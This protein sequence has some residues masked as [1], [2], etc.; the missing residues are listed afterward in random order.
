MNR[1]M[2]RGSAALAGAAAVVFA[3]VI[4]LGQK[5]GDHSHEG[6][7]QPWSKYHVHDMDRPVPPIVTPGDPS[8]AEKPGTA[9]SD[10]VVLFDGKDMS[11][12]QGAGG[13]E[14][15]FKLQ[16]GVM[17]SYGPKN[18]QSK[19]K[20]GDVQLHVEWA[21]PTPAQGDSQGRGNS[22]VFLMGLFETQV[23]DNYHN[24]TY[25]DGQCGAV[26]GQYPPQVNVC[27]PPG[28]WQMYDIIFHKPKVESGKVVEPA[29]IMTLQNGFLVQDHQRIE[30][31]TGHMI[32][33]K[34]HDNFPSEGP[35]ELQFH[36]NPV[37]YRN[38]WARRLE[39]LEKQQH[40]GEVAQAG[41][42]NAAESGGK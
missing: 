27:R 11:H 3:G 17:L 37:R 13:G 4:A 10:A 6:P 9:P 15:T 1:S 41:A 33:A 38:I 2:V 35:I 7:Q 24:P 28:Q 36:G 12:W 19:D 29:Y 21:E 14:A 25:P 18:L 20:F 42:Q 34:Y 26:Y 39:A 22:G 40:T 16:D 30:G 8:T 32:V 31:P 23:L 5:K